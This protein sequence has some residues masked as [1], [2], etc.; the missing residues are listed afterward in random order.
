MTPEKMTQ[1]TSVLYIVICEN[2]LELYNEV[3]RSTCTKYD[4]GTRKMSVGSH[5]GSNLKANE[6]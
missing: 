2:L 6:T 1:K 3:N 5:F 4:A